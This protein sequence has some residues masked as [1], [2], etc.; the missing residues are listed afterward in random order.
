MKDNK[1]ARR[2][3]AFISPLILLVLIAGCP[4]S[5]PTD[6]KQ[7]Q[8]P[9]AERP[10]VIEPNTP[11]I[12]EPNTPQIAEPNAPQIVEPNAPPP[13]EITP[14]PK[15]TFHDKCA[16]ILTTYVN[17]RGMVNY[18]QLKRNRS[19][20]TALQAEFAKLEPNQ[21]NR[22][23][24]EDKIAF[25]IN[26]YNIQLLKIIVNNYPI[27]S[28][29]ILRV[30]WG[31]YSIR[32]IDKTIGGIQKQ[33]FIIMNEEFTLDAIERRFLRKEFDEPRVFLAITHASLSSS[34]LRNEPYYGQKLDEQLDDQAKKFLGTNKAFSIDRQKQK[35]YL[36]AILEPTWFGSAFVNKYGTDKKF[37]DQ[38]PPVRAVLSFITKYANQ[39]D[40]YYLETAN[41]S[42]G[43][44]GYD[45]RINDSSH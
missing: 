7:P 39:K 15:V 23:P 4:P 1:T 14:P 8:P 16:P 42:V 13:P 36:A 26:A 6:I 3:A 22:W 17:D 30:I 45:W 20:L 44:I 41:Y 25:W 24:K 5:K 2:F 10:P 12:A 34:P 33:K 27:E 40:L 43:Y 29:R 11:Q 35:V 31:P 37:K 21:Y 32:H 18:K 28:T 9:E 19:E 38:Q